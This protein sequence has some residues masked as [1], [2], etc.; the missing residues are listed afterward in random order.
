MY[1][2]VYKI[3]N[4]INNKIY[5]GAHS[6][7]DLNDNYL[8]S[9]KIISRAHKKYGKENFKKE[10]LHYFK[11]KDEMYKKEREIVNE[12]FVKKSN[13]YNVKLGGEG[14]WDHCHNQETRDKI[15]KS[16]KE[17][18]FLSGKTYEEAYG[19]EKAKELKEEKSKHFKEV[20]KKKPVNGKNNP[21][22]LK[23]KVFDSEHNLIVETHGNFM[24][25]MKEMNMPGAALQ[26]SYINDGQTWVFD[27]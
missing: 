17:N 24:I 9:G 4:L 2:Y 27:T 25:T 22:A 19:E 23:I 21:S 1:Y 5:I 10:I 8:G 14:G 11:S 13:N 12:D 26:Q 6:T 3:T 7:S 20:R 18:N 15:S 16:Q